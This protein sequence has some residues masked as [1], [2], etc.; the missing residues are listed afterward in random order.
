MRVFPEQD[1]TL[2]EFNNVSV[3]NNRIVAPSP[4]LWLTSLHIF[5]AFTSIIIHRLCQKPATSTCHFY[6]VA[7]TS[8]GIERLCQCPVSGS[9]HFYISACHIWQK[10]RQLCQCPVSGSYHFYLP[11]KNTSIYA[12]FRNRFCPYFSDFSDF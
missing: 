11:L 1:S 8:K 4:C 10:G 7:M 9:Y 3:Q 2:L 12:G 6:D 5:F